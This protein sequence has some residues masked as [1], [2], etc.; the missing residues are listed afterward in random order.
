MTATSSVDAPEEPA[1][2]SPRSRSATGRSQLQPLPNDLA[3]QETAPPGTSVSDPLSPGCSILDPVP[4]VPHRPRSL[5]HSKE[6]PG[7]RKVCSGLGRQRS[8]RPHSRSVRTPAS[9]LHSSQN[10]ASQIRSLLNGDLLPS[11]CEVALFAVVDQVREADTGPERRPKVVARLRAA[12][13]IQPCCA[14]CPSRAADKARTHRQAVREEV[15]TAPCLLVVVDLRR[16]GPRSRSQTRQTVGS[17]ERVSDSRSRLKESTMT[18]ARRVKKPPKTCPV[19]LTWK[20]PVQGPS[21][22]PMESGTRTPARPRSPT[23]RTSSRSEFATP[24]E[25]GRASSRRSG[26]RWTR[27]RS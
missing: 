11:L 14:E 6:E 2:S 12:Q 20:R 5:Q 22:L 19:V 16:P 10:L 4:P 24:S 1:A 13:E 9:S 8:R 23:R 15:E 7:P 21:R 3:D 25:N 17:S 18:R 27:I 26:P